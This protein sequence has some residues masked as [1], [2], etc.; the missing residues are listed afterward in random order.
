MGTLCLHRYHL[1]KIKET[2]AHVL[3]I[4]IEFLRLFAGQYEN[5]G[6]INGYFETSFDGFVSAS[7]FDSFV[8]VPV[9]GDNSASTKSSG[10]MNETTIAW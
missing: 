7:Y 5:P 9:D 10:I 4:L 1:G 6:E 3:F 8:A 2:Y